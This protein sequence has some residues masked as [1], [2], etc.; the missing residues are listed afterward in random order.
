MLPVGVA[1]EQ[2]VAFGSLGRPRAVDVVL[3]KGK[4]A[5]L[6]H[7]LREA[8]RIAIERGLR[9][10]KAAIDATSDRFGRLDCL[11][12]N[13]G[14]PTRGTL[15][16]V[17]WDDYRDAMDLLV[18]PV[19]F[20]IKH[21]A[22]MMKAQGSGAIINN[23]SVAALR[24]NYGGH[25]YSGA[26]AAVRQITKVAGS[27]LA[28]WGITVNSIAPGGIATPIFFGGSE[29]AAG[30]E[31]GHVA[32]SMAKLEKNLASAT[33]M[34]R[35]GFPK[36]IAYGAL[37]LASDEGRFVTCHDLVIDAGMTAAGKTSFEGKTPA[38]TW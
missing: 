37:Y 21:A 25:L 38:P 33:P 4:G 18:A 8:G 29:R 2:A 31:E 11:F 28:P 14:G 5:I 26:K 27:E 16:T 23:A 20:G 10:V 6:V 35:S 24:T 15:E 1:V 34:Q 12:N 9:R 13:A 7:E 19:V 22:P 32:A 17:T 36:D 30:M 3:A